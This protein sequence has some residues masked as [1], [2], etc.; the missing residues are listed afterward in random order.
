MHFAR[1]PTPVEV[2]QNV[3][4]FQQASLIRSQLCSALL[5]Q[6]FQAKLRQGALMQDRERVLSAL[7]HDMKNLVGAVDMNLQLIPLVMQ[8]GAPALPAHPVGEFLERAHQAALGIGSLVDDVVAWFRLTDAGGSPTS[9]LAAFDADGDAEMTLG[10]M[11]AMLRAEFS[12]AIKTQ[13]LIFHLQM[14]GESDMSIPAN[15]AP[16]RVLRLLMQHCL[17]FLFPN[18]TLMVKL[19]SVA[20]GGFELVVTSSQD[21]I[22]DGQARSLAFLIAQDFTSASGGISTIVSSSGGGDSITVRWL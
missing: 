21:A 16:W 20:D 1:F 2:S 13:N 14:N 17:R 4:N 3:Q 19:S 18:Q 9:V 7:S 8:S 11:A 5:R 10:R 12:A 15:G 6:A 22:F